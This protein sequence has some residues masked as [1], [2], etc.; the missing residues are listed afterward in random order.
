MAQDEIEILR[1][2]IRQLWGAVVSLQD[3]V[4]RLT[5]HLGQDTPS[6]QNPTG[7]LG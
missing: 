6:S 3:K 1:E 4:N 2:Q 5:E 7:D